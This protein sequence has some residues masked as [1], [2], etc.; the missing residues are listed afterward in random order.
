MIT[1]RELTA[2]DAADFQAIRLRSLKEHP[3]A[4]AFAYEDE[5]DI[6]LEEV[7]KRFETPVPDRIILGA[8][9]GA[10]LIGIVGGYRDSLTKCR[11]RAHIGPMYVAP[12]ARRQGAGRLLVNEAIERLRV[13]DGVEDII[14]AVTV[15]NDAARALYASVGFESAYIEPRFFKIG[16][17]YYD[18]DWM[19]LRLTA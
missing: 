1:I 16:E 12:E 19:F 17:H 6:P 2:D 15:G 4:F 18:L 9:D 5:K 10:E 11:H 8:F 14:L 3:E 13:I 7:A